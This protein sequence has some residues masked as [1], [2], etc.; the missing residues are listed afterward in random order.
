MIASEVK[1]GAGFF[2]PLR[3]SVCFFLGSPVSELL[4]GAETGGSSDAYASSAW[5]ALAAL[6][7]SDVCFPEADTY[8]FE[9]AEVDGERVSSDCIAL[10]KV[11]VS[12]LE[13]GLYVD[14]AEADGERVSSDC[15]AWEKVPNDCVEGC[16]NADGGAEADGERV[17]SDCIA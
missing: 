11:A 15:I 12:F 13:A 7:K 10:L 9:S 17:C 16:V 1:A 6:W 8:V 14:G 2:G 5:I 4:E 3:N